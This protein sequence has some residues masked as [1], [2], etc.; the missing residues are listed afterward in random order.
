MTTKGQI[1]VPKEVRE[2][3]GLTAGST[4][5]FVKVAEGQYRLLARTGSM[6]D[7]DGLLR[8]PG[9]QKVELDEMEEAIAGGAAASR[10]D[11]GSPE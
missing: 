2:D 1:T 11:A 7:L 4:V 9:Q 6:A 8:R 5:M 10:L 3:L